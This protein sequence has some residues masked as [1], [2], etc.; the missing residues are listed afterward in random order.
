MARVS[1]EFQDHI[2]LVTMT[3][4]D[5]MNALDDAMFEAIVAAGQE[6]ADSKARAVVLS[7]EGK[8]FCAGLDLASFAKMG[9]VDPEK[10]LLGRTHG[11]TNLLQEM[12]L[13]WRRVPVPVIAA[14]HGSVLGG[15]LQ[16]ALGADIR[17]AAPDARLSLMEM[18]WGLVPDLGGMVLLPH[19]V[20]SDILRLMTYTAEPFPAEQAER[21]GLVTRIADDPLAAS[22]ELAR[23]I[24]SKSPSAIRAAKRLIDVAETE[25]RETVL[26]AESRE[27]AGLIGQP[28]QMEVVAAQMQGRA[29][30]FE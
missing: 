15:G 20:R 18:K 9:Q 21:W 24:A 25:A 1:I 3:R 13:I 26:L 17:I 28:D 27:S 6:V 10:W 5:K 22:L 14:L 29:P 11:D 2:A 23:S 16:L 8:S 4:G 19:L 7:G 12:S 30:K